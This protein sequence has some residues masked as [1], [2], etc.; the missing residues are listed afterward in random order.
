MKTRSSAVAT[1]IEIQICFANK[2]IQTNFSKINTSDFIVKK[3]YKIK[4][5]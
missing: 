2:I 5:L 3:K 1:Y 4:R